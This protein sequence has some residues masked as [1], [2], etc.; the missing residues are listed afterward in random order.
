MES[1]NDIHIGS[2]IRQQLDK[3]NISYKEFARSINCER[4]SLYYL[5]SCKSIDI[6]RLIL[7]SKVL[8]FDFLRNIYLEQQPDTKPAITINI[9]RKQL[10]ETGNITLNII[11]ES[12]CV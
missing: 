8:N 5:F 4:Q 6:D 3:S 2:L 12:D 9:P 11:D 1:I 7:I 10:S